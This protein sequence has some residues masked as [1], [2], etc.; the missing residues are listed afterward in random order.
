MSKILKTAA[1]VVGAV[2]LIATGV[3]AA[4]GAGL[5]G[6]A[7]AAG[8]TIAGV[9]TAATFT[10]IGTLAGVTAA[11][12]SVGAALT[13]TKPSAVSTG[14]PTDFSADPDAGIPLAIGRTGT[15]GDITARFGYDTKDKGDNDRQ[16]F[17]ATLSL[18]PIDA[19]EGMTVDK[20]AVSYSAAGAAIGT[21]AGFM[22][23]MTQLGAIPE[24]NALSFGAGAG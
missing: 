14:S 9:A 12:L 1:L 7:A 20:V 17:V 22:W 19:V 21:F 18:G 4:A 10:A 5:L 2:A 8:G 6:A 3:G 23:S 24:A 11:V 15:A 16:S 13:A